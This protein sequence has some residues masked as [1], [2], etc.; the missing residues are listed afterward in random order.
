MNNTDSDGGGN[1]GSLTTAS[2]LGITLIA[3]AGL[4]M[5]T[6]V[7]YAYRKS[8]EDFYRLRQDAAPDK[9]PHL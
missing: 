9:E 2:L 3:L 7:V 5:I 1:D 6:G 8:N 4:F